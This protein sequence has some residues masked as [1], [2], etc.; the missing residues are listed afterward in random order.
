MA[1][2]WV[3]YFRRIFRTNLAGEKTTKNPPNIHNKSLYNLLLTEYFI[4]KQIPISS[5]VDDC[6]FPIVS[7]WGMSTLEA[8]FGDDKDKPFAYDIRK[9]P[10]MGLDCI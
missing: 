3:S 10:G 4:E 6:L 1:S 2:F 9:C 5:S 7:I 8:N